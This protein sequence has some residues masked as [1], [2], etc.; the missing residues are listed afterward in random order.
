MARG[1][2]VFLVI[3][4]T[5]GARKEGFLVDS[6]VARLVKGSDSELLVGILLDDAK[7]ILVCIE[8]G[9]ENEG[10][11]NAVSGIEMLNLPD[12]EI[13]ESHVILDLEGTLG[14]SHA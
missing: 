12:G 7:S 1:I 13:K 2:P 10:N 9:H 8:G 11:I 14:T 4:C 3:I 6:R 5:L